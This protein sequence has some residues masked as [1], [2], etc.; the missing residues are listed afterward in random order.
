MKKLLIIL[1]LSLLLVSCA[2]NPFS[3]RDSDTPVSAAGTF[4]PPT[5]PE[6]VLENLRLAYNE[7][8]ISNFIQSID[9][10]FVFRFDFI[11][12]ATLDTTWDFAQEV[13]LTENLFSDFRLSEGELTISVEM[14]PQFGQE[15]IVLD[16]MAI[17]IRSYVIT[18]SDTLQKETE[19]YEGVSQFELIES[20][21]NY[22]TLLVWE[23]LHVDTRTKSW[24]DL[25]SKYR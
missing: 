3:S 12:G 16:T 23:D 21:F 11:E 10:N 4:I 6:I 25:K 5:S 8:V 2:K 13:N 20:S 22:W 19:V 7:L 1:A 17:M 14:T 18:V 15:D 24:A 9:S